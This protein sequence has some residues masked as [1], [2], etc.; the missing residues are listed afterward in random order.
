[1]NKLATFVSAL[2]LVFFVAPAEAG[3]V[4]WL[5]TSHDFGAFDEDFGPVSCDFKFVNTGNE[6]VSILS[7][8]ASCGCTSPKYTREAVAPGDTAVISVTY[9]PAGRPGRFSKYVGVELSGGVPKIKLT[10]EGTVIGSEGSVAR[11]YPWS[12]DG[13]VQLS[14]NGVL[15]G[16]VKKGKLRTVSIEAYNRSSDTVSFSFP[17]LPKY[18][19][20]EVPVK[21][22]GPGEQTSIMF[23]LRS[24]RCPLYGLVNDTIVMHT[25]NEGQCALNTMAV[26]E[27]DFSAV[28][29]KELAKAPVLSTVR[30]VDFGSMSRG[31]VYSK[32][33]ELKNI[34]KSV[35]KVRRVYS[36]DPGVEAKVDKTEIKPGKTAL[37]TVVVN[38]SE[39]PGALLNARVSVISNDP[40]NPTNNVRLVG[41]L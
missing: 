8:R 21:K 18:I 28:S 38:T 35:L 6:P 37:V 29:D 1:M 11:R 25:G 39:L 41:E 27:E 20:V 34:G 2:A 14:R 30:S 16:Q 7:A 23:F 13:R 9:D 4:K 19:N 12:C 22:L 33:F 40:Q 31:E 10:V 5:E 15:F 36:A 32:T 24:E 26:I 17:E 3:E